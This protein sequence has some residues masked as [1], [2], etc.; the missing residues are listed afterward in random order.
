MRSVEPTDVPPYFW[1]MSDTALRVE[2][3][4]CDRRVRAAES[5]RVRQRGADLHRTRDARHE[6]EVA[7]RIDV[8]EIRRRR[9]DLVAKGQ[10]REHGLDA[11]GSTEQMSGHRLRRRNG[12]LV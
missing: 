3:A 4:E 10:R 6:V 8:D 2:R 12:E 7:F 9:C 1:T 11:C 5:E